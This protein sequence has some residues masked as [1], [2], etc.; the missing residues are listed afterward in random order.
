MSGI[1]NLDYDRGESGA[2]TTRH[3]HPQKLALT[4]PTSGGHLVGIVRS[5]PRATEFVS[6]S[7][8]SIIRGNGGENWR[9]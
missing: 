4:S 1:E 6:Y 9:G 5:R 3:P 7:R 2:L 8:L